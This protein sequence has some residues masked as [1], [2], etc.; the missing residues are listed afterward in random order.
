MFIFIFGQKRKENVKYKRNRKPL[1]QKRL[2]ELLYYNLN[3][4]IFHW[5]T[6][7]NIHILIGQEAGSIEGTSRGREYLVIGIDHK[8]Y[9]AHNLAW[10]Y[11]YGYLPERLDHRDRNGLHNWINNLR[12]CTNSQNAMNQG[13]RSDNTTGVKGIQ[14]NERLRKYRARIGINRERIH[15][16]YFKSLKDAEKAVFAKAKELF[17]EFATKGY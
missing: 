5:I 14:W 16:G 3:T 15:V 1:T 9:K 4:G 11:V 10:L 8:L 17:G 6:P 13:I 2:K 12:E 7:T